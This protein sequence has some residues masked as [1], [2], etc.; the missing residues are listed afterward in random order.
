MQRREGAS[1]MWEIAYCLFLSH[2]V[3]DLEEYEDRLASIGCYCY[4]FVMG[5][6]FPK[7]ELIWYEELQLSFL[8]WLVYA[9]TIQIKKLKRPLGRGFIMLSPEERDAIKRGL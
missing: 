7:E 3:A 6:I 4:V 8:M 9:V 1:K 2:M 5:T